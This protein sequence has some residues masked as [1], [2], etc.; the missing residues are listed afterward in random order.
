[1]NVH[2]RT[3]VQSLVT[4][5]L[6]ALGL[7]DFGTSSTTLSF[8]NKGELVLLR[9]F[10]FGSGEVLKQV[11]TTL[12]VDTDTAQGILADSAFD[13]SELLRES[14]SPVANQLVVSRDFVERREDCS[15]SS[16]HAIGGIALSKAAMGELEQ[17]LS[18][19]I[20]QWDP[21]AGLVM[22][23]QAMDEALRPQRW[24][25]GAAIGA[26]LAALEEA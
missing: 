5:W 18:V 20:K 1:M 11:E 2:R 7:I 14:L 6:L 17:A 21:F 15:I 23:P 9:Q 3:T 4:A 22:A 13:I 26:A 25:F 12:H 8:F 24:R 19:D 16:L 10:E